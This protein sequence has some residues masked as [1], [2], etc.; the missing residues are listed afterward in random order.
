MDELQKQERIQFWLTHNL[1]NYKNKSSNPEITEDQINHILDW[2]KSKEG[3]KYL[4]NIQ[5]VSIP[6]AIRLSDSWT[7]SLNKKTVT[8]ES[9]T[10]VQVI[11]QF[12]NGLKFVLLVTPQAYKREGKMMNHCVASYVNTQNSIICSLRNRSNKP[13]VTLEFKCPSAI[14]VAPNENICLIG[15]QLIQMK[16]NSNKKPKQFLI[17][18]ILEFMETHDFDF[19]QES[20]TNSS[21]LDDFGFAYINKKII[22]KENV[23][24]LQ[25]IDI[26]SKHRL[27]L[28]GFSSPTSSKTITING[29]L[30][31]AGVTGLKDLS[32]N[33]SKKTSLSLQNMK[34]L[35][36]VSIYGS[37]NDVIRLSDC[38][39][40]KSLNIHGN[41]DS[42][43]VNNLPKSVQI[44]VNGKIHLFQMNQNYCDNLSLKSCNSLVVNSDY[45]PLNLSNINWLESLTIS[46]P[47][48][49][50]SSNSTTES[51]KT[52]TLK[53]LKVKFVSI[54]FQYQ[55]NMVLPPV[56]YHLNIDNSIISRLN[57][58]DQFI[59]V[60]KNNKLFFHTNQSKIKL[61]DLG[62]KAQ[63]ITTDDFKSI[64]FK[65]IFNCPTSNILPIGMH[66]QNN[67]EVSNNITNC[68]N[69]LRQH[70]SFMEMH[71]LDLSRSLIISLILRGSISNHFNFCDSLLN[72]RQY[73]SE[74]FFKTIDNKKL[75][76]GSEVFELPLSHLSPTNINFKTCIKAL[77]LLNTISLILAIPIFL[78]IILLFISWITF[79]VLMAIPFKFIN[80]KIYNKIMSY[81]EETF[82]FPGDHPFIH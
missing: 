17:P 32:V 76:I 56:E 54:N 58:T 25:N 48:I 81:L 67:C 28:I 69:Q 34:E 62:S 27:N 47:P 68:I 40:L 80:I 1:K 63:F 59:G 8:T 60:Y 46:T 4:K 6:T 36:T 61:L 45:F 66:D 43:T 72:K 18:Y 71:P 75:I 14:I 52:I 10:D 24:N 50:L 21:L 22:R 38:P 33:I 30:H 26:T 3:E 77:K 13:L 37:T 16:G 19:K 53:N 49:Y 2:F 23:L 64:H 51:N 79:L 11:H 78:L 55:Q 39:N 70:R 41:V 9:P 31:I 57:I 15:L 44:K 12:S 35:E 20:F 7:K 65:S 29:S 5:K 74:S 73:K 82:Q 42:L